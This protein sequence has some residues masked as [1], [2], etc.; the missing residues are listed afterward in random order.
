LAEQG[1][2]EVDLGAGAKVLRKRTLFL[3]G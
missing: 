1:G 2:F 3:S